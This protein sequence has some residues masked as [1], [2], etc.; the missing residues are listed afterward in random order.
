MKPPAF[1]FRPPGPAAAALAPLGALYH[2]AGAARRA[3]A[4]PLRLPVPVVCV[5]NLS[6]GGTGKTPVVLSLL[7]R[8][9]DRGLKPH[10]L[11]RGYG[12]SAAGP[13]RV[14]PNRHSAGEVGDEPLL[15]AAAAP[16]WVARDR[17]AGG[18]AAVE[19]GAGGVVMDDGH[20]NAGLVKDLS[21]VVVDGGVGFGN[22][23]VFPAGPLRESV[24]AG[25]ARADALI[26]IGEDAQ[27]V[28][29]TASQRG[30]PVLTA[31]LVPDPIA[32]AS[33]RGRLVLAFAGIGRPQKFFDALAGAAVGATVAETRGFP[34]HHPFTAREL[35][36]LQRR[37][38]ELGA[39]L[40]TTEKDRV[41]LPA[42]MRDAVATLPVNLLWDDARA[43]DALLDRLKRP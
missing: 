11:S 35:T 7:A 10:A 18:L 33:L 41:R 6:L 22:G 38:A 34:D 27:G 31:R 9:T 40:A 28:A 5:G 1:W 42:E 32:A 24:A 29:Q 36:D 21:L 37:A 12:G 30:L 15:L 23:R 14:D 26:V 16:A 17:A 2:W 3:R 13:L 39:I 8:L 4:C 25:L 43:L 19:S 20:Q